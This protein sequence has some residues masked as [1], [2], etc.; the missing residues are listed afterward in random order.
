MGGLLREVVG[1]ILSGKAD[2]EWVS[3]VVSGLV[4]G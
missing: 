3:W 1:W 4:G 2:S